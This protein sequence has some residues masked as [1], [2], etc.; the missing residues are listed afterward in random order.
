MPTLYDISVPVFIRAL[1]QLTHLLQK[2]EAYANEKNIPLST[3]T[4]ASLAP[5]MLKLP[6]QIQTVSNTAKL[7]CV[8]VG[9]IENVPMA[10]DETTFPQLY[11]RIEKTVKLLE[12][13]DPKVFEGKETA[14]VEMRGTKFTGQSYLLTFA[15]PNFFFHVT[16]A[17]AIL[18]KEGVPVGKKDFL[19]DPSKPVAA[20]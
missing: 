3:L 2:A 5:D 20:K 18:R 13:V 11:E 16:A 9:L 15:I 1:N 19:G 14:E 17:Y 4:E 8:R 7:A 12:A 10:D 6:F